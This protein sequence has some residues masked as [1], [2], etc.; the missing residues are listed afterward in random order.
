MKAAIISSTR[1][2]SPY[3]P[4]TGAVFYGEKVLGKNS[5]LKQKVRL[6]C[7]FINSGGA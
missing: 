6:F 4:D 7:Q 2:S 5:K 1:I 3:G